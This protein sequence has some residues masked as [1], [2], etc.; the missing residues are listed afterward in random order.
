MA[1]VEMEEKGE[2]KSAAA[3]KALRA[4]IAD[5]LVGRIAADGRIVLH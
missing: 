4:E 1:V 5:A 2:E 3:W